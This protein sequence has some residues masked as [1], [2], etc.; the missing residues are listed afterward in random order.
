M[1]RMHWLIIVPL[2]I[3]AAVLIAGCGKNTEHVPEAEGG[4]HTLKPITDGPVDGGVI[5]SSD[6]DA[7]KTI[8]SKQLIIFECR[9]ST[10]DDA[11][12]GT[13][14]NHIYELEARLENGAVKGVYRIA[15]T[16]EERL[17]RE[18]HEFLSEIRALIETYDLAQHN[19]HAYAVSGL[20][21]EYGARIDA[22][23][24]SGESIYASDNQ[25][26]FLSREAM[27]ALVR[28]FE[29]GAAIL[30]ISI[31]LNAETRT[32]SVQLQDGSGELRYPVYSLEAENY[33]ALTA[34][35][36]A[37]NGAWAEDV[38]RETERFLAEGSGQLYQRTDATVTRADSE[39]VSFYE[40][41]LRY[42]A[43]DWEQPM[44]DVRTHNLDARSG[45]ELSFADVF[46]DTEALPELLL[47]AFKNAYPQQ[48]FYGDAAD[49][50]RQSIAG[51]DGNVCFA[52]DYGCV[53]VFAGEYILNDEA[54]GQRVTLSYDDCPDLVRAFYTTD[55]L[56]RPGGR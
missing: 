49:F 23:Y 2:A 10:M 5:D 44:T 33:P 1:K 29:R 22:Q 40:I 25:E 19:G 45:R 56:V 8:E 32:E 28:L 12:P 16:G 30:P 20:P 54:G 43:A 6:P 31:P 52:L 55:L 47:E 37:L 42:E 39:A 4:P 38:S 51:N 36:N 53:H 15:D 26:N 3:A 9:F 24:A 7:P 48:T 50:I 27:T 13:L 17:F 35:L 14:G 18:S 34:A 41:T 46:C 21:E 11:E